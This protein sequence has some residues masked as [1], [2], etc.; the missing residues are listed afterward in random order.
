MQ[1]LVIGLGL[2]E[3]QV[4]NIMAHSGKVLSKIDVGDFIL[5]MVDPAT[6]LSQKGGG[7]FANEDD[8]KFL[9]AFSRS[10]SSLILSRVQ[11]VK[12]R[13]H[14]SLVIRR[15]HP[16]NDHDFNPDHTTD[17]T[18]DGE[19]DL[20]FLISKVRRCCSCFGGS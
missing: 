18:L 10:K 7:L 14:D 3:G 2:D 5:A 8:P 4:D 13:E 20:F 1:D 9:A 17:P 6:P 12:F 19:R 15:E 11:R 16:R